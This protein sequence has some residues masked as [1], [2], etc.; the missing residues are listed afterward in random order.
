MCKK[1]GC[2][3]KKI[4]Y[5]GRLYLFYKTGLL[6]LIIEVNPEDKSVE[7]NYYFEEYLSVI[8]SNVLLFL[9]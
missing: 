7:N 1:N 3:C 4:V 2:W 8:S 6:Y 5:D 9:F